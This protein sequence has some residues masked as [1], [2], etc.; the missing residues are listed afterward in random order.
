MNIDKL[1]RKRQLSVQE[2]NALLKDRISKAAHY[3][4]NN[5]IPKGLAEI[6]G[7]KRINLKTCILLEYSQ[8]FPGCSIDEG[9][10]VTEDEKF[11][12][13]ELDLTKDRQH[14]IDFWAWK[15]LTM[16]TEVTEHKRGTG[17]TWGYLALEVLQEMNK[18]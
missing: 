3:W 7:S 8:D 9:I 17:K 10:I 4:R 13:F 18:C 14:V 12:E 1:K 15:D 2:Q 5:G 16:E 6:L 11:F